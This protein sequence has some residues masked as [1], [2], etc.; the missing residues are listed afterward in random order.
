M[1]SSTHVLFSNVPAAYDNSLMVVYYRLPQEFIIYQYF[2]LSHPL[3]GIN[4]G[5][6][7]WGRVCFLCNVLDLGNPTNTV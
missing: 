6:F 2:K 5:C 3:Q 4:G 7:S 1:T